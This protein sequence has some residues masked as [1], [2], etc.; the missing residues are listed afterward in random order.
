MI[1]EGGLMMKILA[2]FQMDDLFTSGFLKDEH[3]EGLYQLGLEYPD[4]CG[5]L[6]CICTHE[7]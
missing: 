1:N 7:D 4:F 2:D 6:Y 5:S 3:L